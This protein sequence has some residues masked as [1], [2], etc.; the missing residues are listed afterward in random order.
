MN[1]KLP[2]L[3]I[4]LI[5]FNRLKYLRATLES[6]KKCIHYPN[7]EWIVIDNCSTEPELKD[8][9]ESCAWIDQLVFL[10][11]THPEAMNEIVKRAKGEIILIWPEDVQFI[12]EGDWMIDCAEVLMLY[13]F[14]G[15]LVL[16][17]IRSITIQRTWGAG[18]FLQLDKLGSDLKN[19]GMSL[20]RRKLL[21]S[22]RGYNFRS[23]GWME[24]GIAGAGIV[25]LTRTDV[26]RKLGPWYSPGAYNGIIDSSR[27]A[28]TD[29]LLRYKKSKMLLHRVQLVLPVAADIVDDPLGAKAKVRGDKRYG[30]YMDPPEGVFY[31]KINEQKD[32]W[33]LRS[34]KIPLAFENFVEPIGYKLPLD[35]KG[36]LMKGIINNSVVAPI[37]S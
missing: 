8:Y 11:S 17:G 2:L 27:G 13:P 16:N 18:A 35:K 28:E 22:F 20:R 10:K 9:L 15:S 21:T 33:H 30:I 37:N 19:H 3:T 24:N 36:N 5:S 4:G 14:I 31:Y 12:V 29:M 25:S 6:M 34:K 23:Y 1:N 26:W 7:I 32:V